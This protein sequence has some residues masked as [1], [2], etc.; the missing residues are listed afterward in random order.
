M[1]AALAFRD[2]PSVP[3]RRSPASLQ[4]PVSVF[5]IVKAVRASR[6]HANFDQMDG[7][8]KTMNSAQQIFAEVKP[9]GDGG[10]DG[11]L[12]LV[13][14]TRRADVVN[15]AGKKFFYPALWGVASKAGFPETVPR[16]VVRLQ[17]G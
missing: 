12:D 2:L 7:E 13:E 16:L 6:A 17:Q 10:D 4:F 9:Q 8:D 14:A 1:D 11:R 5:V 15:D 3:W